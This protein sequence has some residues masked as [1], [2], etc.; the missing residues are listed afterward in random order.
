[1]RLPT[2]QNFRQ[3]PMREAA[4]RQQRIDLPTLSQ[5]IRDGQVS[6]PGITSNGD[7]WI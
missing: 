2:R 7:R 1:M 3:R 4:L 5:M 6:P